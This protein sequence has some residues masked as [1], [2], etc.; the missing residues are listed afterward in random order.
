MCRLY[1]FRGNE[2][3]RVGCT[4]VHAQNA[5][6]AQSRQ[7]GVGESHPDGWG[8][9]VYED[10]A[11]RIERSAAA[12]FDDQYFNTTAEGVFARTVIA[13]VRQATVGDS[14]AANT[15]P[16]SYRGWMF[17]HNGTVTAFERVRPRMIEE[18]APALC[19]LNE[20]TTDSE[21]F[22]YWLLSRMARAGIDLEGGGGE[23]ER[24]VAVVAEALPYLADLCDR[25]GPEKPAILNLLLTDGETLVAGRWRKSLHWAAR[26]GIRDCDVCDVR[27][28]PGTD[29]RAVVIASE[30]LANDEAW[31]EVPERGIVSVDA[32]IEADVQRL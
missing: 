11:P 6:L 26:D 14:N 12:A 31:H 19:G 21:V 17:A 2:P 16:F 1:G 20:G 4:L 5:L 30:A 13:H 32:G 8:I 9:G 7:D 25:A 28:S 27:H 24:L 29:Y 15:H 3:T 18:T 23:R 22:F 10:A